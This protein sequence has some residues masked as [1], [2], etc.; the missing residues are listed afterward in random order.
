MIQRILI[1][2]DTLAADHPALLAARRFAGARLHLLHVLPPPVPLP[3][4][5]GTGLAVPPL[6][7]A[8]EGGEALRRAEAALASLGEGEVVTSG[9]PA[10]EILNRAE[11]GAF[12]LI[13][14]GTA[15]RAGLERLLL[16]SVA[17]AVVR[18]SPIPVLTVHAASGVVQGPLRRALLLHDFQP[19]ADRALN[20][21][22]TRL[23]GLTVD[24]IHVVSPHSL[25]TP[26]PVESADTGDLQ[27]TLER[28][29]VVW[30]DEAQQRLN[31]LGGG[32][33]FEGDPA[34]VALQRAAGGGYDLLALGTSSRGSL[35]RLLFGS[36]AQQVVRESPL[37]VLTARQ[38]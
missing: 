21:L 35:D 13:V 22:R 11:S 29:N 36:V 28:R 38:V 8:L 6:V 14:M 4:P 27:D 25:T 23:P 37:P 32:R 34:Q 9:Q 12:D 10:D 7:G 17:E 16:G 2:L 3:G 33:V 15:G 19:H 30:K 31:A 18:G 26:F 5:A 24:L 20:F 1:P